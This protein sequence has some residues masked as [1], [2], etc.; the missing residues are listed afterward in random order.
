MFIAVSFTITQT[1][2]HPRYPW[3]SQWINNVVAHPPP[4][5]EGGFRS[6]VT[7]METW[8]GPGFAP[9]PKKTSYWWTR[10]RWEN[11]RAP[12]G[13]RLEHRLPYG[14]QD[15]WPWKVR[16]WPLCPSPS[17]RQV[18]IELPGLPG[19]ALPPRR[20]PRAGGS[21]A[22]P[23]HSSLAPSGWQ[24]GL[25]GWATRN[26]AGEAEGSLHTALG[27][28][29]TKIPRPQSPRACF[30][31]GH[32][33]GGG[34]QSDQGTVARPLLNVAPGIVFSTE[35]KGAVK[36][37]GKTWKC[38]LLREKSPSEKAALCMMTSGILFPYLRIRSKTPRSCLTPWIV[39]QPIY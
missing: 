23:V 6:D 34:G 21:A 1:W 36:R 20:G 22:A 19:P 5:A 35:K 24:G 38:M 30:C 26:C 11:P 9:P 12:V 10:H 25:Q 17:L 33:G 7:K 8:V 32:S 2:E 31:A 16:G 28:R 18:G 3:A 13:V 14:H 37:Q 39:Q 29:P 4:P 27:C 15:S